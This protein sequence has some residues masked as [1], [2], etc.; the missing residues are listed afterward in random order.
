[1]TK[2]IT[3]YIKLLDSLAI[4][5]LAAIKSAFNYYKRLKKE[6]EAVEGAEKKAVKSANNLI[7]FT[8]MSKDEEIDLIKQEFKILEARSKIA[9][10][11]ESFMIAGQV[12]GLLAR[13][14]AI[15]SSIFTQASGPGSTVNKS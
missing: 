1:M 3:H 11:P 12:A 13:A 6:I 5:L 10:F 8:H 4:A 9:K 7:G 15:R 14:N 2:L